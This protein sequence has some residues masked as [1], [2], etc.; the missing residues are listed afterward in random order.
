MFKYAPAQAGGLSHLSLCSS[1]D[2]F[3][4]HNYVNILESFSSALLPLARSPA[5]LKRSALWIALY[6][7]ID[8]RSTL[9]ISSVALIKSNNL[10]TSEMR[11]FYAYKSPFWVCFCLFFPTNVLSYKSAP[12]HICPKQLKLILARVVLPF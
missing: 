9:Q 10:S 3:C 5:A 2:F 11:A 7:Q 8:L 6:K 1:R 4:I 12:Y